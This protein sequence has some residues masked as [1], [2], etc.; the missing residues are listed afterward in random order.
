M[1]GMKSSRSELLLD[2]TSRTDQILLD[3]EKLQA[4]SKE[5]LNQQ[6]AEGKWSALEC[7]EHLNR[8]GDF[9][10]PE[11]KTR[12]SKATPSAEEGFRPGLLGNYFAKSMLPNARS[13]QTFKN[14][15]PSFSSVRKNVLDEFIVQ[16]QHYK[17]LLERAG[18]YNLNSIKTSLSIS[19]WIKLKLGDTFRVVIYHNQRHMQQAMR[20]AKL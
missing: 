4:Q 11:I 20:A 16:Q 9:Y 10:L 6:P 19:R 15:N 1:A 18:N 8:Y 2:L 7:L 13:M 12:L 5:I 3:C 14:M 17:S